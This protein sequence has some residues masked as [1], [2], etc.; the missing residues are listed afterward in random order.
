MN[1]IEDCASQLRALD[2]WFARLGQ[3]HERLPRIEHAPAANDDRIEL[4][5]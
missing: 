5:A 3:A 4:T 2:D 1:L